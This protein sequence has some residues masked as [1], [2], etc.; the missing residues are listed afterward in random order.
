MTDRI[1]VTGSGGLIGRALQAR[2]PPVWHA[3]HFGRADWRERLAATDFAQATVY[4][5]A[6]RVHGVAHAD[7]SQYLADN[8]E[9]T[10]ML[11]EAAAAGGARRVVLLSTIKVLGEE[12]HGLPF[13]ADDVPHPADAYARSKLAGERALQDVARRSSL[14]YAIVRSPLVFAPGAKGNLA[15]LLRLCDSPL[16]LPFG[17]VENRRSFV[18]ADDLARLLVACGTLE[19]A[20]GRTYLA[21]HRVAYSTPRLVALIR[22]ALGR[23]ARLIPVPLAVLQALG[24]LAGRGDAVRRLGASLEADPSR[25]R[26]ELD[27][28]ANVSLE[29]CV[30]ALVDA[31]RTESGS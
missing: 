4:H 27:W 20:A 7:E 5:L 12:T 30:A 1:V 24:T 10:R 14:Q 28:E 11:A 21:A 15:S 19:R 17:S 13:G 31:Y 26:E 22:A 8:G 3:L 6:A 16:P 29:S 23:P 9:K 2:L 18:D 25:A